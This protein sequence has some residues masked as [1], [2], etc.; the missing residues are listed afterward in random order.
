MEIL[1][2]DTPH[3]TRRTLIDWLLVAVKPIGQGQ[4]LAAN[5]K[6]VQARPDIA[7]D[8]RYLHH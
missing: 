6:L 8:F 7:E 5:P 4:L 3:Y 1:Y 2:S